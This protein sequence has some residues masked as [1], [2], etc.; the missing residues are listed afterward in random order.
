M[1]DLPLER[2]SM[3]AAHRT[4]HTAFRQNNVNNR[5]L[6]ARCLFQHP[7]EMKICCWGRKLEAYYDR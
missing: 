3:A 7:V 6:T 1:I 5:S 2:R 4:P